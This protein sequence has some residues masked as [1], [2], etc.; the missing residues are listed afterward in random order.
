M[1]FA[2]PGLLFLLL[3]LIP[4]IAWYVWKRK[5]LSAKLQI[6]STEP[7]VGA[8][9]SYKYKLL[10]LPFIMKIIALGILFYATP[11]QIC[12]QSY[13]I[14][15]NKFLFDKSLVRFQFKDTELLKIS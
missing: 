6:S 12:S 11:A 1:I 7:F 3:L 15:F 5:S 9:K 2:K 4:I 13:V 10:H 14:I 8:R